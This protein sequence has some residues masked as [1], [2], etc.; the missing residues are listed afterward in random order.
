VFEGYDSNKNMVAV[1]E[2][3]FQVPMRF[4]TEASTDENF[5]TGESNKKP[6]R[7]KTIRSPEIKSF[8]KLTFKTRKNDRF[9]KQLD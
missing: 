8:E 3:E 4:T 2:L 1:S 5:K 7:V 6:G 9:E